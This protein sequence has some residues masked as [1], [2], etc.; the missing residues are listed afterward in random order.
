MSSLLATLLHEVRTRIEL[1]ARRTGR[2]LALRAQH[3]QA[4]AEYALVVLGAAAV[5]MLLLAWAT[6]T[7]KIAALLDAVVDSVTGRVT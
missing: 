7:G 1:L 3:G 6:G 5:A 2:E 4:T